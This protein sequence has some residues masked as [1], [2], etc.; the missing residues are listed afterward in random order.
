M[1]STL[2]LGLQNGVLC[3]QVVDNRRFDSKLPHCYLGSIKFVF[4]L[5]LPESLDSLEENLGHSGSKNEK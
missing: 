2:K 5:I 4:E 3:R 1:L